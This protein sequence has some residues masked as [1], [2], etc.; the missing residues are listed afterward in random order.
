[1]SALAAFLRDRRAGERMA[2]FIVGGIAVAA[3]VIAFAW[4][5]LERSRQRLREQLPALRA[6]VQTLE[7]Q[8]EEAKRLKSFPPHSATA[9]EPLTATIA[10]K[11]LPGAQVA[12]VDAKTL[13]ITASDVGFA[14]LL[15]WLSAMQGTQA[16]RV[17]SARIDALA[18]PGRVRADLRLSKP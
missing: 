10:A 3:L 1:M 4:L 2:I 15:D 16:L 18:T 9:G 7:R 17:E 11:P 13:A 6:S 12:V 14:A 8:A 5:P